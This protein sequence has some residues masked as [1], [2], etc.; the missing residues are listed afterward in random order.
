M[1]KKNV[2]AIMLACNSTFIKKSISK[3]FFD[4]ALEFASEKK[5]VDVRRPSHAC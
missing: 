2:H 5:Y 4:K 1:R 3:L